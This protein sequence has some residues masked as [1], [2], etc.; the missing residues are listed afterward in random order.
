MS[1][2]E[3]NL[4][5]QYDDLSEQLRE[6][7]GLEFRPG[8]EEV[9]GAVQSRLIKHG[10]ESAEQ[11]LAL[12]SS[13]SGSEELFNLAGELIGG[14]KCFGDR[15]LLAICDGYLGPLLRSRIMSRPEG[16]KP[17][18][19]I[20]SIGCGDGAELY[21]VLMEM[22]KLTKITS[23]DLRALGTDLSGEALERAVAGEYKAV[24]DF[25]RHNIL[26]AEIPSDFTDGFNMILC[27]G[28]LGHLRRQVRAKVL[29]KLARALSPDGLLIV[30]AGEAAGLEHPLLEALPEEFESV[31]HR[32]PAASRVSSNEALEGS[33]DPATRALRRKLQRI[34]LPDYSIPPAGGRKAPKAVID[35]RDVAEEFVRRGRGLADEFQ[36]PQALLAFRRASKMDPYCLEAHYLNG[37]IARRMDRLDEAVEALERACYLDKTLVMAHFLLG[38]IYHERGRASLAK[39]HYG[40]ALEILRE[41]T[42]G[43]EIRFAED[44]SVP[45]LREL[46]AAGLEALNQTV[47]EAAQ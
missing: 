43:Q 32:R 16:S 11:Y 23:W 46:C 36:F 18:L 38:H 37:T 44:M 19:R 14:K 35:S 30:A 2:I 15:H 22:S 3:K 28:L 10:L 31:L 26:A 42:T 47:V 39:H 25:R 5:T 12:L 45:M 40:A 21:T 17:R 13:S 4:P 27:R 34:F 7:F 29:G 33:S 8:S 1:T 9:V 6:S 24:V 41:R 20:W